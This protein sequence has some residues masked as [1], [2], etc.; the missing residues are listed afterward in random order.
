[1]H[2]VLRK[3]AY[4]DHWRALGGL[5]PAARGMLVCDRTGG[6]AWRG[7]GL[8][9]ELSAAAKAEMESLCGSAD[10]AETPRRRRLAPDVDLLVLRLLARTGEAIGTL[11]V[12]VDAAEERPPASPEGISEALCA[13]AREQPVTLL[14]YETNC[15]PD[16]LSRPLSHAGL[17]AR[18]LRARL[19][20]S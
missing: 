8:S 13:I 14:D 9:R 7:D 19:S 20:P 4:A 6:F 3:V 15:D 5:L 1:M 18:V 10:V 2:S 12:V 17:V 16:D 11:G